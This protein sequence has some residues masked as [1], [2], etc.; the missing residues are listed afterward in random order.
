MSTDPSRTDPAVSGATVAAVAPPE[1]PFFPVSPTKLV[2]MSVATLGVY[3]L[4]WMFENWR[5][6][7]NR[8]EPGLL[9][10]WRVSFAAFTIYGLLRRIRKAQGEFDPPARLMAGPLAA[11]WIA[12]GL[13]GLSERPRGLVAVFAIGFLVPVQRAVNRIN[14]AVAPGHHPNARLSVLNWITVVVGGS[15]VVLMLVVLFVPSV[16]GGVR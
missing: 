16:R 14:N 7:R 8:D 2:V 1:P 15:L 3:Q 4:F 12:I 5:R 9:P 6:I 11:G 10:A 13:L